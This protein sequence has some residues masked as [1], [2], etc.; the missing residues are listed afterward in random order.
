MLK[1]LLLSANFYAVVAL[2]LIYAA[3]AIRDRI[4][5]LAETETVYSAKEYVAVRFARGEYN[6]LDGIEQ[7]RYDYQFYKQIESFKK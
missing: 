1:R 4:K 2:N 5:T 6:S 3:D 7:I